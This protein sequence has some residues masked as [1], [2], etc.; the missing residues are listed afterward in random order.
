M[1]KVEKQISQPATMQSNSYF[2]DKMIMMQ[3][4]DKKHIQ[5]MWQTVWNAANQ[6]RRGQYLTVVGDMLVAH[7]AEVHAE[8]MPA[9]E[10]RASF[11]ADEQAAFERFTGMII[12]FGFETGGERL[13]AALDSGDK[14]D[15]HSCFSDNTRI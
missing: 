5:I 1:S 8:W 12:L 3:D 10:Y 9:G 6:D 15:E 2:G 14:E 7:A 13:Q 11:V 4:L